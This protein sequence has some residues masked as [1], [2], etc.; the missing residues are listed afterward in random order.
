MGEGQSLYDEDFVRWSEDQ[1]EAMRAA[2]FSGTNLPLDWKNLAEEIDSLG[3][4]LRRELQSRIGTVIEH[5]LELEHS[6]A[7]DPRRGWTETVLRERI[8]IKKL[9][10]ANPSLKPAAAEDVRLEMAETAHLVSELLDLRGEMTGEA[11]QLLRQT[12]YEPEQVLGDWLPKRAA[13]DTT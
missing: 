5:L 9:L 8:E 12:V 10:R 11:R 1:A 2:A 4:S 3:K 6:P 7:F 13:S